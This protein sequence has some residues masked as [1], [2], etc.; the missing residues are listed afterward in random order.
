MAARWRTFCLAMGDDSLPPIYAI[1]ANAT[2]SERRVALQSALEERVNTG[3]AACRITPLASK[4]LYE[5]VLQG[6]FA[7]GYHEVDDLTK[8]LQPFTCGFQS[9][10]RDRDV[11]SRASQ[12]DQM[13]A[14]LVAPSLAE[15]ETFRT[16]EVPLPSM[17]YQLGMQL[18]CTSIVFDVVL[19]P[20][21]PLAQDLRSFCLNEWP[22]VEAAFSTSM[23]DSTLVLPII[24]RWFQIEML[25]FFRSL[26]MGQ[27]AHTPNF[28][29]IM[30]II[31]QR[32]YHLF[33]LLPRQ[34][35]APAPANHPTGTVTEGPSSVG[36]APGVS[37]SM[38]PDNHRDPGQ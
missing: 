27:M 11:A 26:G 9:T 13:M 35:L 16:K 20:I 33:P 19:G 15:Q 25:A 28:Q 4:E 37:S 32:A 24:L 22:L 21:H 6:H 18:G 17:V 10:E 29:E 1:W 12:F 36:P 14:G 34:Y 30:A 3:L 23:D 5:I 2:K 38:A 31:K 8:G 7:A